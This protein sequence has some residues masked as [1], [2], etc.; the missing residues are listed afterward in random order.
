MDDVGARL[1]SAQWRSVCHSTASVGGEDAVLALMKVR[2]ITSAPRHT[3]CVRPALPAACVWSLCQCVRCGTASFHPLITA[4]VTALP[5]MPLPSFPHFSV[6]VSGSF[7]TS[8]TDESLN[9]SGFSHATA[10][11]SIIVPTPIV[12]TRMSIGC[13]LPHSSIHVHS[14]RLSPLCIPLQPAL[15]ATVHCAL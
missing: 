9:F 14:P 4:A 5:D 13:S 3:C 8:F 12:S 7:R 11:P 2:C 6:R 10:H 1:N 15:T